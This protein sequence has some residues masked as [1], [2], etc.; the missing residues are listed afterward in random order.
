MTIKIAFTRDDQHGKISVLSF[1]FDVSK[2]FDTDASLTFSEKKDG[3]DA[4]NIINASILNYEVTKSPLN[5]NHLD[6]FLAE[7]R[8]TLRKRPYS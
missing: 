8:S 6:D 1:S 3:S 2:S 7:H 5:P 4:V